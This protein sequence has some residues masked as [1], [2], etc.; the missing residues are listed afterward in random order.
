MVETQW[1]P[2][3]EAGTLGEIASVDYGPR[4]EIYGTMKEIQ[5]CYMPQ[6]GRVVFVSS[7]GWQTMEMLD[8]LG[9][10]LYRESF[11]VRRA[12]P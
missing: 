8:M 1:F 9:Q 4:P 10:V 3:V 5:K 12:E 6:Q 11:F 7:H 2:V